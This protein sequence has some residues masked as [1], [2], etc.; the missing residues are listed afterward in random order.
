MDVSL[1]VPQSFQANGYDMGDQTFHTPSFGD[2]EFDIPAIN[3][4]QQHAANQYQ[5]Q[6][7]INMQ[8]NQQQDN[9]GMHDPSGGYQQPLYLSGP[10]HGIVNP[11][12]HSPQP[13]PN[14]A[15]SPGQQQ[16]NN[17]LLMMQQQQTATG[18]GNDYDLPGSPQKGFKPQEPFNMKRPPAAGAQPGGMLGTQ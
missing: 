18:M 2:E 9:M 14:Y 3:P 15:M 17:Q 7:Q 12:Y 13:Q 1:S 10:D 16:H 8:M 6:Q 11:S 4:E 5:Q